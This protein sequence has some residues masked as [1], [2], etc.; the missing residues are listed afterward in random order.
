MVIRLVVA[1]LGYPLRVEGYRRPYSPGRALLVRV[2]VGP[3]SRPRRRRQQRGRHPAWYNDFDIIFD[4]P[5]SLAFTNAGT[6]V[7]YRVVYITLVG[8]SC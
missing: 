1:C 6:I 4:P 7:P 3:G 5:C 2:L 8:I